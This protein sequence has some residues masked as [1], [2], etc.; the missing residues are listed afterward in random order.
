MTCEMGQHPQRRLR[1]SRLCANDPAGQRVEASQSPEPA[2]LQKGGGG[3][4]EREG[5]SI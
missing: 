4:R 5:G 1:S 3:K 2:N